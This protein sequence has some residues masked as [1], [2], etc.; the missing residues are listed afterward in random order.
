VI[1]ENPPR[2]LKSEG[3]VVRTEVIPASRG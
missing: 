3:F 2:F 1:T